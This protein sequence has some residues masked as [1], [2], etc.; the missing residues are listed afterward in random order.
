MASFVNEQDGVARFIS[1]APPT[2]YKLKI[3]LFSLLV[4]NAVEKYE[5]AEFEAGG[6]K[7]K[8]VLY[9]NGNKS[10]NV[11][12]HI[13]LY[14]T[15]ADTSSLPLG[16]EVYAVV[17]LFLLDQSKDNYLTVQD[18]IGKESYFHELKL[19][20]G[21]DHFVPLKE[22]ND[23]SN[24]YLVEDKCV[25][26]TE[27]FV[28]KEKGRV[29]SECLSMVK[30]TCSVKHLW[31]IQNFS[32]LKAERH[33]SEV[34]SA[35]GQ[36][37]KIWLYPKGLSYLKGSHLSIFLNLADFT[38]D[39]KVYADYTFRIVDQ[40]QA[41][42]ITFKDDHCFT[43]SSGWG[44]HIF[45]TCSHF[46]DPGN[47]YL[48]K[49]ICLVEAEV[50]VWGVARFISDAP[51]THYKLK[52]QLFSLLVENAV[53]KYESAEFEAGGYKW[54]LVLYPNGNKSKNVKDHISLY[55][56]LA[57]TSSLPLG[58]E[59]YAVFRLFLLDQS[60]D[61]YLTI[62][63]AT[64]KESHFHEL[65]LECG[66]D[67]FVPLK[68]FNDASNGY[69]V[70][71]K[72]VFGT[73]VFVTKER[74]RVK[75]ECLSMVKDTCSVKHVWKI[76]NF[77]KLSAEFCFS[78]VF[79]AGGQKW[80]IKLYPNG[81]SHQ[82]GSHLSLYLALA[83]FTPY[84]KIYTDYTLRLLD[85]LQ[86][87]HIV[88]KT[89]H[90]FTAASNDWGWPSFVS[91][92]YLNDPGNGCLV[93]DICLVE[94]EVNVWGVARSISD[95]PPAHYTLKI[96]L[97]SLLVNTSGQKYESAE[98]EAG[99]Y[100]WK[101]A[102]YP[103]GN[104][105]KNV[106]DHLS[107]YLAMSNTSSLRLGWEVYAVFR[108]FLLDQNKDNYL[109]VQD[110]MLKEKRFHGLKLEWG[111]D[112]F[113]PLKAFNDASN[114]YLVEDTCVFGAEVFVVKERITGKGECLSMIK[115]PLSIKHVWRIDN[116][117]K[118]TECHE[119]KLFIAG[120]QK[121]KIQLYPKGRRHGSGSHLSLYLAMADPTTLS[122]ASKIY[123]EFTLRILD[124][125]QARHIAGKGN[126]WFST[127][128]NQETGWARFFSSSYFN[129][130]GNG[131]LVKDVCLVEAEVTVHG[132]AS[133]L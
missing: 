52:I 65:K 87:K 94:A 78:E 43:D 16:W 10:K 36:K 68:E 18:A 62:Q 125:V 42:H 55:L 96:Q 73:E 58:W 33:E 57:N 85:Q 121:W 56:T 128:S 103:N 71:D 113:L 31:K 5:S 26:G 101:L 60:K 86:A 111:I 95:A 98:F 64:G 112:Q 2:H 59:V 132:I 53:E 32:K 46:N 4:K 54:R 25:F 15:L 117:S 109:V 17:R 38:P 61:N 1:D 122:P 66:F 100:K 104:K 3:Q 114:G 92:S 131:L 76:E 27:I 12:D 28:T 67:H 120:D 107:L 19:E 88:F 106:K 44:T 75:A 47:G 110:A 23:A 93:K 30:D 133:A 72:C 39:S 127:T 9:P 89:D 50:S 8:L 123:A 77:S 37:W 11:R 7:W 91:L 48:V 6:Y 41:K 34:F 105:S 82:K 35:G 90:C 79:S 63:D 126:Y 115:D 83:D 13:S 14:L 51:P 124:Q 84:S 40:L 97:F 81:F 70:E 45:V 21:F 29:K 69:L 129:Q 22:F 20:C 116:F 24:G 74:G 80:K 49:D 130:P 118:D 108:F 119:S 102:L 99:G